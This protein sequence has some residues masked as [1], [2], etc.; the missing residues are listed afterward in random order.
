MVVKTFIQPS[1]ASSI[2]GNHSSIVSFTK[3]NPATT[4]GMIVSV[5][6]PKTALKIGLNVVIA[7]ATH[8]TAVLAIQPNTPWITGY[9]LLIAP[10]IE[11]TPPIASSIDSVRS[12]TPVT[13]RVLILVIA[14][15]IPALD[16]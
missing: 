5:I 16:V 15:L 7:L 4:S 12:A 10:S 14:V 8:G 6:Q 1:L 3:V 9:K 2:V 11:P 13:N